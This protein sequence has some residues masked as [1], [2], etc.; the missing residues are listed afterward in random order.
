M[1]PLQASVPV[2]EQVQYASVERTWSDIS[3]IYDG[4]FH[5]TSELQDEIDL[6]HELVP[7][8]VDLEII[9][10]SILGKNITSLRITNELNP[11]QKAK[12]LV[13]G[14]HHA[15]EQVTVEMALR[16]ILRLLN[17]YG[18]DDEMTEY[19]DTQEIFVIPTLNPDGLDFVVDEEYYW[20]RKNLRPFDNDG[21]G[22][23]DEDY[24]DDVNDDGCITC[25]DVFTKTGTGGALEYQYDYYEGIDNDGDG[26]VNEDEIGCV[27][28]NRNYPTG[29]GNP[30]SSSDSTTQI[31]HGTAPFSE[32]ETAAFRDFALQHRF[33]MSYSLHTGINCTYFPDN[34]YGT[35]EEPSLYYN[36]VGDLSSILPDSFNEIYGI[37]AQS[38][39]KQLDASAGMWD[40]W[41]YHERNCILPITFE[42]YHN[43][44]CNLQTAYTDIVDN[45]THVIRE[46]VPEFIYEYFAPVKSHINVLWDETKLAF[47]YLL[48]QTPRVQISVDGISGGLGEETS[49][50]VTMTCLSPRLGT[51]D[52][53]E[54]MSSGNV[55]LAS[56]TDIDAAATELGQA[57]FTLPADTSAGYVIKI[58]NEYSG[59]I[60]F[61]VSMASPA[62]YTLPLAL[63]VGVVLVA[64]VVLVLYRRT[65]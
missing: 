20:L 47:D 50:S 45:A 26:L 63:G 1:S 39:V 25:W 65:R 6:I 53:I 28:L 37:G 51:A 27:D 5:N 9:G 43:G 54:I 19:V 48:E 59:Y 21:D 38:P 57:T 42:M 35:W 10:Q 34:D 29:F 11:E 18:V 62:D 30:G 36:V 24:F 64:V 23:F 32:P 44:S 13:V 61:T 40:D 7:D 8:L 3:L 2:F 33:A 31:Y 16:F 58:G 41:M 60:R 15:R 46:Y 52:G 49:V 14:H 55:S 22:L 4:Q 17:N 12:T 56:L